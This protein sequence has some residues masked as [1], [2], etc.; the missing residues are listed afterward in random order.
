MGAKPRIASSGKDAVLHA[1]T[2]LAASPTDAVN[3]AGALAA[4]NASA[5]STSAASTSAANAAAASTA[6]A[7]A[8]AFA[9]A[10][11]STDSLATRLGHE[12]EAA[13]SLEQD[14][15]DAVNALQRGDRTDVEGVLLATR[16]ADAAFQMIQAVRNAML[17]AYA[18]IRDMRV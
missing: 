6:A 15:R 18:E 1:I 14:A 9:Q 10:P 12:L 4:A 2:P 11:A 7:T 16:K 3:C 5:A 8:P 17:Q 13:R